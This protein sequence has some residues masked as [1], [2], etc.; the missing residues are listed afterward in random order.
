MANA[1]GSVP[2][3]GREAPP[4]TAADVSAD[5]LAR[6]E[7]TGDMFWRV[8]AVLG[9][10]FV[11]GIIGFVMRMMDGFSD[12]AVWGYYAAMFEDFDA[13]GRTA[14]ELG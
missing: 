4:V 10:L 14:E 8:V 13:G 3:G 7:R 9:I 1:N 5:L 6:H 2:H 12:K 11:L